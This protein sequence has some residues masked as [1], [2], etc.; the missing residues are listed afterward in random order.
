MQSREGLVTQLSP[1]PTDTGRRF[2]LPPEPRAINQFL[3]SGHPW[4]ALAV[5][6]AWLAPVRLGSLVGVVFFIHMLR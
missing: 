6:L 5:A 3:A 4:M 1:N 2:Q